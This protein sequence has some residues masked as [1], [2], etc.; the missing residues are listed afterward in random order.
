MGWDDMDLDSEL[1]DEDEDLYT[2]VI[3]NNGGNHGRT[4]NPEDSIDEA[5]EKSEEMV[6]EKDSPAPAGDGVREKDKND[7]GTR[8]GDMPSMEVKEGGALPVKNEE[9]EEEFA[10][11]GLG[12]CVGEKFALEVS[13]PLASTNLMSVPENDDFEVEEE[14]MCTAIEEEGYNELITSCV[15]LLEVARDLRCTEGN[16]G[17]GPVGDAARVLGRLQRWSDAQDKLAVCV[18]AQL[19][20]TQETMQEVEAA[21]RKIIEDGERLER[22][23]KK[24]RKSAVGVSEARKGNID[25]QKQFSGIS[26][27]SRLSG[28]RRSLDGKLGGVQPMSGGP[29]RSVGGIV[30][31]PFTG[32]NRKRSQVDAHRQE[33]VKRVRVEAMIPASQHEA[34]GGSDSR[35][36]SETTITGGT[37]N[38]VDI[39]GKATE[40]NKD[41]DD[42]NDDGDA[43]EEDMEAQFRAT[44]ILQSRQRRATEQELSDILAVIAQV[45]EREC[46]TR[47]QWSDIPKRLSPQSDGVA[48]QPKG[49]ATGSRDSLRVERQGRATA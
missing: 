10:E 48:R 31:D 44:R 36:G 41:D 5:R 12:S 1:S 13:K 19:E 38:R 4:E 24:V 37:G 47:S 27:V 49:G 39:S 15:R 30:R 3:A 21:R 18:M 17:L 35:E 22:W 33:Q 8:K 11:A 34:A 26:T 32:A 6:K 45:R 16:A 9:M 23:N 7:E 25:L 2:Q 28:F 42:D 46:A 14:E 29:G 20:R 43:L 40:A